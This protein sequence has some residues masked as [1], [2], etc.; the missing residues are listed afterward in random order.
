MSM[1]RSQLHG[2]S[3][4]PGP[5][6]CVLPTESWIELPEAG[7]DLQALPTTPWAPRVLLLPAQQGQAPMLRDKLPL[8]FTEHQGAS[9]L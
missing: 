6:P 9:K 5:P 1:A 7:N 3:W 8:I 2:G 4:M